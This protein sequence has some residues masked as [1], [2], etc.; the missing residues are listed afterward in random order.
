MQD[1]IASLRV[2]YSTRELR[3]YSVASNPTDQFALWFSDA[4]AARIA[5]PNAM[6]VSTVGANGRPSSR[7]VLLKAFDSRGFSFFTNLAS[8]KAQE[9][10]ASPWAAL[11]LLWKEIERQVRIEGRVERVDDDEADVYFASRPR[12]SQIGAWVSKQSARLASRDVLDRR[13]AELELEFEGV[14]VPRPPYWGGFRVVPDRF[15]FWQ[16]RP[17]RLHDRIVY[18][19]LEDGTWKIDRLF[20]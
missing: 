11:A 4:A 20:P 10:A 12:G 8:R 5:E 14:P 3:R 6:T 13:T 2:E 19:L 7:V 1:D 9:L 15:E 17:N 16:G 18:E